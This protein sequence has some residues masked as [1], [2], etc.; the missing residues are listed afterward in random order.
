MSAVQE[1][2]REE[3]DALIFQLKAEGT[4][5]QEQIGERVGLSGTRVGRILKAGGAASNSGGNLAAPPPRVKVE[6]RCATPGCGRLLKGERW[7]YSSH[8][9]H[10]YC[11]PD[12][13]CWKWSEKK[14]R[15]M[16]RAHVAPKPEEVGS[17]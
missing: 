7:T 15:Q 2:T 3:R 17:R 14:K 4:L 13:G 11:W 6:H 12:E 1:M 9:G 16:L 10:R 5:S 8:T